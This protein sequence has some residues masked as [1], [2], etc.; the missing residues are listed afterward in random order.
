MLAALRSVPLVSP[1]VPHSRALSPHLLSCVSVLGGGSDR[2]AAAAVL[3]ERPLSRE[4]H[5]DAQQF[6][7]AT[8]SSDFGPLL[9]QYVSLPQ[10]DEEL[11]KM[12]SGAQGQLFSWEI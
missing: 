1:L 4:L 2:P 8:D 9:E 3:F 6:A 12:A 10:P 7:D 5:A 11:V